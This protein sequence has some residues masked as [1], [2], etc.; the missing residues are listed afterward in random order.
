M[1]RVQL[2]LDRAL[3]PAGLLVT[4]CPFLRGYKERLLATWHDLPARSGLDRLL[5]GP[6]FH[7]WIYREYL[8]E[9]DPDRRE[10]MKGLV[11]GGRSGSSWAESYDSPLDFGGRIGSLAFHEAN[12]LFLHLEGILAG[13]WDLLVV[14]IGC[15]S[16]R[17]IGY[18]AGRYPLNQYIGTDIYPEVVAY[19]AEHHG[20]SNLSWRCLAAKH[21]GALLDEFPGREVLVFS[22]GSLQYVQPEHLDAFFRAAA[23]HRAQVVLGETGSLRGGSPDALGGSRWR[24]NFSYTHDYRFYAERAGLS[25]VACRIIRPYVPEE[26]YGDRAST[27]HYFYAGESPDHG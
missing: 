7:A 22:S 16:G 26:Q 11:M 9:A 10:A 23:G 2:I 17:E 14:Q 21:I 12:P 20:G 18:L 3:L 1:D 4:S 15:S 24:D 8:R 13:T 6:V 27:I 25:T 19:A 5:F